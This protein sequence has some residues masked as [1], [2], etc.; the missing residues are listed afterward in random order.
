MSRLLFILMLFV[1]SC[2][3]EVHLTDLAAQAMERAKAVEADI[4]A[5]REYNIAVGWFSQMNEAL[6]QE[7]GELANEKARVVI[8][9]ANEAIHLARKNKA[10]ALIAQLKSALDN[11]SQIKLNFPDNYNRASEYLASAG[12]AYS[13]ADYEKAIIDAQRGLDLLNVQLPQRQGQLYT[14]IKG[15]TLW[16]L[17]GKFYKNPYLWRNI[18]EANTDI[19]KDPH[20]I[21]PKQELS[22]PA[23]Q[24]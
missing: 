2:A 5:Q 16:D 24:N 7:N 10:A 9:K 1:V 14:V 21:Y 23:P 13:T 11:G 18:Y 6:K 22:I 15:D 3:K 17:S 4:Y 19:I 8:D 12:V 20:W